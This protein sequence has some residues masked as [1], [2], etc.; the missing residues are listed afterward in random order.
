MC[1][2]TPILEC[3]SYLL[4]NHLYSDFLSN[5]YDLAVAFGNSFF[6]PNSINDCFS[7]L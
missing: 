2:R 3:V 4:V 6:V 1:R 5:A 7:N